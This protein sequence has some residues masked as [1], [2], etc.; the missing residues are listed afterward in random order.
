ML[1][2][3]G[4]VLKP[5]QV[6]EAKAAGAHFAVAPGINPRVVDA[7]NE[8]GIFFAPGVFTPSDI[9][10]ALEKGCTLMNYFPADL[11]GMA[12]LKTMATPYRHLGVKFI[13]LGGVKEAN[14]AEIL[15]MPLVAAVGG[16][17]LATTEQIENLQTDKIREQSRRAA[18]IR[19]KV[20]SENPH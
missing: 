13:P 8:A 5:S 4:T 9:E 17:W 3:A 18:E 16:S 7:A 6:L 19:D 15:A 20:F 11:H 1:V 2:G 12:G 10:L 14:L